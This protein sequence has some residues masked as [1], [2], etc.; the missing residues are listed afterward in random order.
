MRLKSLYTLVCFLVVG[1]MQLQAKEVTLTEAGTL[2]NYISDDELASLTE[3]TVSGPING[4]DIKIIQAMRSTL[5]TLDLGNAQIVEGG[6][7]YYLTDNYTQND[8][9]GDYMFYAMTALEKIVMPKDVWCI[10]TWST[11]TPWNEEG[12]QVEGFLKD[13]SIS[14]E[15]SDLG[16]GSFYQCVNLKEIVFPEKLLYIGNK[17]FGNCVKLTSI[18]IPEG[19]EMV[20]GYCF[21][22]CTALES[23]SIPSTLGVNK[24][25]YTSSE[26][27]NDYYAWRLGFTCFFGYDIS[28]CPGTNIFY[29]CTN[30]SNVTLPAAMKNLGHAM[31]NGCTSLA[32]ITLPTQL[33]H[34]NSAFKN[35]SALTSLTFPETLTQ[36]GSLEGCS[37]LTSLE[38]PANTTFD[39]LY[40]NSCTALKSIT[41]KGTVGTEIPQYAFKN[42]S[43]L[44]AIEVPSTVT[45][46]GEGTF[47]GCTSL[48]TVTL[49]TALTAI[50][51]YAFAYSGV[52]A[53]ALDRNVIS[54][55]DYAFYN[56]TALESFKFSPN[57][58][59]IK[60]YTFQGCSKLKDVTL[61]SGL[62]T[63]GYSAFK[64]CT[65]LTKITIPGDVQSIGS[66]AF[67][68]TGLSEVVLS[69]GIM[70]LG[71]G[72]FNGCQNLKT[73]TFPTTMTT[74]SGFNNTGIQELK[75]ADGAAPET[76]G[77]YA[78]Q[79]CDSLRTVTL[80][81]TIK[82]IGAYAFDDCDSLRSINI[83]E[84]VTELKEST[85]SNCQSLTGITL[86][87]ALT[88][89]GEYCFNYN[90]KLASIKFP[91]TLTSLGK[92]AF[93]NCTGL[94]SVDFNGA[95]ITEIGENT[96]RNAPIE[97]INLP[98]SLTTIG[99]GAFRG[100]RFKNFE[101]PATL[102]TIGENAFYESKFE[103]LTIP[104]TVTSI[105]YQAF[106]S[107]EIAGT[108]TIT[109]NDNLTMGNYAFQCGGGDYL[110]DEN[111]NG[112]GWYYWHLKNVYWNSSTKQFP[113]DKFCDIDNLYLPTNG[114]TSST[115]NIGY[116]F[117]NG[118]TENID[119][120]YSQNGNNYSYSV[121]NEMKANRVNYRKYFSATS[122]YG[123][124]AGWKT[125]VLPYDVTEIAYERSNYYEQDTVALAPFGSEAL[126]TE[127][128]LPFWLY[129]LGSD[130]TFKAATAIK[131]HQPYLICMPNNDKYP[132]EYNISGYVNFTAVDNSTGVSLKPTAGVLKPVTGTKFNFVPTYDGVF[133]SE[134]VYVLNEENSY[135]D[136]EKYLSRGSVFVKNYSEHSNSYPAVYP[137]QA[138]LTTNE[139][140]V[141]TAGTRGPLLYSI[142]GSTGDITGIDRPLLPD[143]ATKAYCRNGVLY[144][145]SNAARTV[146]IYNVS[147]Q[148]VRVVELTEGVNEVRGLEK[149]VYLLEGQK[150]MIK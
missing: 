111:G 138:Y 40:C 13:Y 144:I 45:T 35:C 133:Q 121:E 148:T 101:I 96:F 91:Q 82:N 99:N 103:N 63:L 150:V 4:S 56:C 92:R 146:R 106:S 55:G 31:F 67:E 43:S 89:I 131:A 66:S 116:I 24:H 102:T 64:D 52:T 74:I 26:A 5:K 48:A 65:S 23:V 122:G 12:T 127:G 57:I 114:S 44:T 50:E 9:I 18:T 130:G 95:A 59:E 7:S 70:S 87:S 15:S 140:A 62:I 1:A 126:N 51:R 80:P 2:S 72:S 108:L 60:Y 128:T 42:C 105:G 84:G 76:I 135:Y 81:T 90:Y 77:D 143:E 39:D 49:P 136:G 6:D 132:S 139:T 125:L 134:D 104:A 112:L 61:P 28:Y 37:A 71:S 88:S 109:P 113:K 11:A 33:E 8:I 78:F 25:F 79:N 17:V 69:E 19:V 120:A 16:N 110:Y 86:P 68:N 119:L 145:D 107:A 124:A 27:A 54:I 3:L 97:E 137:F 46:I 147:G 14:S 58:T 21:Y 53:I 83:P 41:F 149:G 100:S 22:N 98:A 10:G 36:I 75:F 29:G 20:G 141:T 34:V 129:E 115:D 38:I 73:V 123:E 32:T 94:T 93:Y 118:V 47:D 30:L 142:G 85:F 117:Y